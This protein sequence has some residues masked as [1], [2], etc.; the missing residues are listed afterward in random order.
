MPADHVFLNQHGRPYTKDCLVTKMDRIRDRAQVGTK[1]GERVVL[2]SGRHTFG[3]V[4]VG[5]VSDVELADVTGHSDPRMLNVTTH[6]SAGASSG[7]WA[8][9]SGS[10]FS[11]G[12][13]FS[14]R[15]MAVPSDAAA[16]VQERIVLRMVCPMP[17]SQ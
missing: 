5:Q 7:H 13:C 9:S 14:F 15:G 4:H 1:G 11:S 12:K 3:T 16:G 17:L 2:Y 8:A 10:V 6:S